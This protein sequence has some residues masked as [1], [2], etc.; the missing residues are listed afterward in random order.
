MPIQSS[1][2]AIAAWFGLVV[3]ERC[4]AALALRFI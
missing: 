3:P 4:L 1:F 2:K